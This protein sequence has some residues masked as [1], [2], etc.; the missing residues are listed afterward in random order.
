MKLIDVKCRK[1]GFDRWDINLDIS[2]F[3]HEACPN[4]EEI[5]EIIIEIYTI[6]PLF[7]EDKEDR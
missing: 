7:N 1:C 5:H 6:K 2:D 4:C 3:A